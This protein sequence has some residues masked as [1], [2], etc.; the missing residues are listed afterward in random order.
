ME[1]LWGGQRPEGHAGE[2]RFGVFVVQEGTG[3]GQGRSDME[4][5]PA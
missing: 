2:A 1:S 3:L 5:G 4:D